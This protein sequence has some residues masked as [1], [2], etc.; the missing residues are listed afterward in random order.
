MK[1][2]VAGIIIGL[3]VVLLG[4][5]AGAEKGILGSWIG[6]D[7]DELVSQWGPPD[8]S[9]EVLGRKYYSWYHSQSITLPSHTSGSAVVTG[10]T[11]QYSGTTTGGTIS[12]SCTRTM[13]VQNNM[14]V[15]GYSKGDNCCVMAVAGYCASLT[16]RP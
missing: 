15:K 2:S 10:N 9:R 5:A 1:R 4:C 7:V 3:S 8:S 12:G 6:S 11:V 13:E 14:I 16:K